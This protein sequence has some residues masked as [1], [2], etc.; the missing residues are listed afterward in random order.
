MELENGVRVGDFRIERRLGA[1][2]MGIVYRAR[3]VSLDRP[4]AL[5]VLGSALN[6]EGDLARFQREAQA[7]ARLNHPGIVGIH[8][9][10]QDAQIC[11]LAMEYVEGVSF[12]RILTRQS[13][14]QK[15]VHYLV[16]VSDSPNPF[17]ASTDSLSPTHY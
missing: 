14:N 2:G 12:R 7:I 13:R 9:I 15:A 11:F 6:H 4:V 3:Q 1:G 17:G 10:G 8:Y 16:P 5:K